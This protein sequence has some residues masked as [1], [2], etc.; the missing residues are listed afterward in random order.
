MSFKTVLYQTFLE[1]CVLRF[2]FGPL[3]LKNLASKDCP[4]AVGGGKAGSKVV[5]LL[6]PWLGE[7]RSCPFIISPVIVAFMDCG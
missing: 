6:L 4:R 7:L 5:S 3:K 2:H 1:S